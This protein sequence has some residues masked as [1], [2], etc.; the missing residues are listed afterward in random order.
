MTLLIAYRENTI[1]R[2]T[3][4]ITIPDVKATDAAIQ[5]FRDENPDKTI[6]YAFDTEDDILSSGRAEV[7][8]FA[9]L[10]EQYGFTPE[11][12]NQAYC[13]QNGPDTYR[14]IGFIPKNRKY[15]CAVINTRTGQRMKATVDY[16]HRMLDRYPA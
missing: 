11:N 5:I 4:V 6:M 13:P 1:N 16:V 2:D 9:E 8:A 3:G 12:Y 10:C 15:K 7:Q 14:L